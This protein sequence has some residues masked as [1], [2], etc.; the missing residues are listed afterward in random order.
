MGC[1]T[2]AKALTFSWMG[3]LIKAQ[4]ML[5]AGVRLSLRQESLLRGSQPACRKRC[6]ACCESPVH[7]ATDLEV[8]GAVWHLTGANP[9]GSKAVLAR[10]AEGG[11]QGCPFLH[12]GACSVYP[13]RFLSCRQLVVFGRAC[14][15]GEDPSRTRRGDMLTLMRRHALKGYALLLPHMGVEP[16]LQDPLALEAQVFEAT[17]PACSLRVPDP[18][19]FLAGMDAAASQAALK[20]ARAA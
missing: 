19:A 18:R 17:R 1:G 13:M 2:T 8:A 6:S 7:R 3:S 16:D 10:L 4:A 14:A 9:P 12:E 20:A 15:P 11:G 5:E